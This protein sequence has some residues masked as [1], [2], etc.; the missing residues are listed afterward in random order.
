MAP[1]GPGVEHLHAGHGPSG[2]P[3]LQSAPDDLDLGQLG[4]GNP[5]EGYGTVVLAAYRRPATAGAAP[6]TP[7]R[8]VSAGARP[9][10]ET[11]PPAPGGGGR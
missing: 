6:E 4:H 1:H 11:A 3:A 8:G 5:P 10:P 2:D 7:S 9:F